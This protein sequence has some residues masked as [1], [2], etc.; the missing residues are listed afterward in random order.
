MMRR[1]IPLLLVLC[2]GFP[3]LQS[4]VYG[5][6]LERL[7]E[8]SDGLAELAAR[9]K[10][11]VVAVKIEKTVRVAGGG[12][13]FHGTP[14]EDFLGKHP[15]FKI[16]DQPREDFREGLGSGVIVS[17]DGYILTN[18]HV[19]AGQGQ[20][21][22]ADRIT[23]ELV[24]KR[25]F[26]AKVIGRDPATDLAVLKIDGGDLASIPYGDSGALR[27]GEVVMAVGNP[28]GQLHTVTTG[29]VSAV[30]RDVG[31]AQY[32]DFVQT[33][34][35]I[36]PGNSGG[37]LVNVRGEL[38][39]INTAI[40]G[41]G[42]RLGGNI[43]GA[44]VGF[45][46]PVNMARNIMDKLIEFGEVQRAFLGIVPQDIDETMA[47]AFG[48]KPYQGVVIGEVVEVSAATEAGLKVGDVILELDGEPMKSADQLRDRVADYAPGSTVKLRV[49]REGKEKNFRVEL[50][51]RKDVQVAAQTTPARAEELGLQVQ[52]L[53]GELAQRLG[54][55][56]A[57]G[58]LVTG[59]QRGSPAGR[60]GLRQGDLIQEV[61]REPVKNVRG[62]SEAI[63]ASEDK[64][65][66]LL[67]VRREETT[68]FVALRLPEK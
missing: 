24:D 5:G 51:D 19:I 31:L 6:S 11:A 58:V 27:V 12:D 57:D 66:V 3:G 43:G 48:V 1:F 37:A 39:G 56:G 52:E 18:N 49:L 21:T 33:D 15:F 28:F 34:A 7:Q 40:I 55:E 20:E 13:P 22:V 65:T 45:A 23:V 53:T 61:N 9:V 8:I 38:V 50:G 14:F 30:G 29:I 10:P 59:V 36:N 60:A 2:L 54:Y 62:F 4:D 16:P 47:S 63:A 35:A 64:G 26:E 44:G 41:V 42:S 68:R 67:L 17:K 46:I 25:T 32:E